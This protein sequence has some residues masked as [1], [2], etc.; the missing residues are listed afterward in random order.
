[1]GHLQVRPSYFSKIGGMKVFVQQVKLDSPFYLPLANAAHWFWERSYEV[2][3]FSLT[4]FHDGSLDDDFTQSRD[5]TIAFSVPEVLRLML[6]RWN[7]PEPTR[8]DLPPC[9]TPWIGRF[10]WETTLGQ[11]R[12]QVD[13][14][15]SFNPFHIRPLDQRKL[16]KGTIVYGLRDLIPSASLS[17][18]TP[19]LAQ[20]KVEF[21]SEW[22]AFIFRDKIVHLARTKGDVLRYP[23]RE[24]MLDAVHAFSGRPIAYGMDWGITASGQTLLVEVN[25][26]YSGGNYGLHGQAYVAMIE[27]RWRE[28]MGLA[29]NGI[30]ECF[31]R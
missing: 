30:G 9:L 15:I 3:R 16:F 14:E 8:F 24:A 27:A 12:E 18:E 5:E 22:R 1:M 13:S 20:Q 11:V 25:D 6:K 19:V 10:T 31:T 21:V 7:R 28:L 4:E 29:D 2:H 23:D 26:G 17:D